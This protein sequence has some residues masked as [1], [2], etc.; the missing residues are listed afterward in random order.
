MR[1]WIYPIDGTATGQ[2]QDGTPVALHDCS[3]PVWVMVSSKGA[4]AE[5]NI[6]PLT[7]EEKQQLQGEYPTILFD[8]PTVRVRKSELS[9]GTI[10]VPVTESNVSAKNPGDLLTINLNSGVT[11]YDFTTGKPMDKPASFEVGQ[12]YTIC[13]T[14]DLDANICPD[15]G[16]CKNLICFQLLVLPDIVVWTP[17]KGSYNG[18]GLDENWRGWDDKDADGDF[19]AGELMEVGYVPVEG[20]DVIIPTLPDVT[21]YPYIHDHNHYPMDVNAHPSICNDVYFA[22]GAIIHNQH[23]LQYN[24]AFVDMTIPKAIGI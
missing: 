5:L 8:I 18:W 2:L 17:A 15:Q 13:T 12:R 9:G 3:E 11:Y 24:R 1:Y 21:L 23:L 10:T 6:S 7:K 14:F 19:D 22:P 4:S 20:S 16:S